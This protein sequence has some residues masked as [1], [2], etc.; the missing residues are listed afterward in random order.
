MIVIS[1][2]KKIE[3]I[4][5][6]LIYAT[7]IMACCYKDWVSLALL[8]RRV[9]QVVSIRSG[10]FSDVFMGKLHKFY[11]FFFNCFKEKRSNCNKGLKR[12]SKKSRYT[13]YYYFDNSKANY[14][15]PGPLPRYDVTVCCQYGLG[16]FM[17][18][19]RQTPAVVFDC[20]LGF[21]LRSLGHFRQPS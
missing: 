8:G 15:Y 11:F 2:R 9:W 12:N 18:I 7:N 17:V 14:T 10:A 21:S 16:L 20:F 13:K 3:H 5:T 4:T 19:N 6:L 1:C